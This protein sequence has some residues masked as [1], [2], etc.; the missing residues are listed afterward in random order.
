MVVHSEQHQALG[1][2]VSFIIVK[3]QRPT[4]LS[5][6]CGPNQHDK[7]NKGKSTETIKN[8][9]FSKVTYVSG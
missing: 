5:G 7:I 2:V 3:T 1:Y 6:E 8:V 9:L 4:F